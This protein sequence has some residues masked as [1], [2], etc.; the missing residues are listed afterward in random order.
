MPDY[1]IDFVGISDI[2]PTLATVTGRDALIEAIGRRLTTSLLFYSTT[3]GHDLRQYLNAAAPR[4]GQ[5]EAEIV[6][7][8]L[9]DDRLESASVDIELREDGSLRV[10]LYLTDDAGPFPL[11]LTVDDVTVEI[12]RG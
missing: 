4:V 5:L 2:T 9:E 8:C 3:Y 11:T 6:D 7:Q 1:G 12:L 10:D